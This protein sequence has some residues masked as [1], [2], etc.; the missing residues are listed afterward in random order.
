[1]T[2]WMSTTLPEWAAR[3]I[4]SLI[5]VGAGY[6]V[7]HITK[8]MA[9][10]RLGAWAR[11]T[12]SE[13]DDV[14][15][16][17]CSRRLPFWGVLVGTYVA[18][19]YWRLT[20]HLATVV[21]KTLFSAAVISATFLG[22]TIIATS[23]RTYGHKISG[24]L[25]NTTLIQNVARLIVVIVGGL[26]VLNGLGVSI[27][28]MLTALGVGGLAVALALQDTLSNLFSG[29]QITLAGQIRVGH[30][31]KLESGQEGYLVDIAWRSARLRTL[32]NTV[33]LVPNAKL[34][35]AIVTN[36]DLPEQEMAVLVDLGVD[37]GSDLRHV[38]QVTVE[39]ARETLRATQGSVETFEPF[40]RFHTFADSSINFSVILRARQFTDQYLIKHEF[41]KRL[42]ERYAKEGITIPFPI[43]TIVT[44][45]AE[46]DKAD[47]DESEPDKN[48]RAA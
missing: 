6:L 14:V 39:V 48:E 20:P 11:R 12:Q 18:A 9:R 2:T 22:A 30:Y 25:P 37:Y 15:V 17:E 24:D 8:S 33:I 36:Y 4:V 32:P 26:T 34:A 43:R 41:V 13:W 46:P 21:D 5:A 19:S 1:M 28:P 35:Q 10:R 3:L 23:I 45:S 38:E 47:P 27:A 31:L 44:K 7:G 42:H 40:I 16:E 29:I